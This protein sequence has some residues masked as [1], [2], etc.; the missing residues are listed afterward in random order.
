MRRAVLQD[1]F[2]KNKNF[3]LLGAIFDAESE[4]EA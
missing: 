1:L 2:Q 3:G 4:E